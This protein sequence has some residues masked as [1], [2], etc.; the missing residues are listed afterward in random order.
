MGCDGLRWAAMLL[1]PSKSQQNGPFHRTVWPGLIGC[2]C[3]SHVDFCMKWPCRHVEFKD[4]EPP[5]FD[6]GLS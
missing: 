4:L 2:T 1:N 6:P 3:I 5:G